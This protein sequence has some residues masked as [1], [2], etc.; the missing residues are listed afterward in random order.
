VKNSVH[1]SVDTLKD[2]WNFGARGLSLL[3][4]PGETE[5]A[6]EISKI[7]FSWMET[8]DFSFLSFTVHK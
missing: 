6:Q 3:T 7:G 4:A 8:L 5:T 2:T 1:S